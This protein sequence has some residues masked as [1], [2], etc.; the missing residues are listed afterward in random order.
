[1][2]KI[3]ETLV[4]VLSKRQKAMRDSDSSTSSEDRNDWI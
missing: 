1:M 4:D 2:P 3:D